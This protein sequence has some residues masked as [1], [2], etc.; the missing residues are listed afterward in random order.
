VIVNASLSELPVSRFGLAVSKK[1]GNAVVRNRVKRRL[2][3][4]LRSLNVEPGWD[5]VVISRPAAADA[6]FRQLDSSIRGLTEQLGV[7]SEPAQT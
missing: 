4:I 1:V 7:R 3:E 2:R 5:V 6:E